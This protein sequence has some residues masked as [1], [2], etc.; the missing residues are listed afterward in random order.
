MGRGTFN[1]CVQH[2]RFGRASCLLVVL[3]RHFQSKPIVLVLETQETCL[4]AGQAFTFTFLE[5]YCMKT[6]AKVWLFRLPKCSGCYCR[7]QYN[8][9]HL[10]ACIF[11]FMVPNTVTLTWEG[12]SW[13]GPCSPR[14][15]TLQALKETGH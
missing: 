14:A 15:A 5:C 9:R 1:T 2:I 7:E 8:G 10:S 12:S 6:R 4:H 11:V 3:V 13:T